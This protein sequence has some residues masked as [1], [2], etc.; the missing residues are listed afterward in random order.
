MANV[1]AKLLTLFHGGRAVVAGG[2]TGMLLQGMLLKQLTHRVHALAACARAS[3][4]DGVS[5]VLRVLQ[6]AIL[7]RILASQCFSFIRDT[8]EA[9]QIRAVRCVGWEGWV[10]GASLGGRLRNFGLVPFVPFVCRSGVVFSTP[11]FIRTPV[12][13]ALMEQNNDQRVSA[14]YKRQFV[15]AP[16][17]TMPEQDYPGDQ[18]EYSRTHTTVTCNTASHEYLY[19]VSLE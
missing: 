17:R 10:R 5:N 6:V 14:S 3:G 4:P 18:L 12:R 9:I 11:V 16:A 8:T 13:V 19:A 7:C 1:K 2:S 15:C